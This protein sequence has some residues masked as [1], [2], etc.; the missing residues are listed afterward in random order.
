VVTFGTFVATVD[1]EHGGQRHTRPV[2]DV[3]HELL[4]ETRD[5]RVVLRTEQ[6]RLRRA[7]EAAIDAQ[8]AAFGTHDAWLD[9]ELA[10]VEHD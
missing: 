5:L 9:D 7:V 10:R 4:V 1:V 2:S 6:Q 3:E 8:D